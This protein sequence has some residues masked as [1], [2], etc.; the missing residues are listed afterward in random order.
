MEDFLIFGGLIIT[1]IILAG[2][3]WRLY[4]KNKI[5]EREVVLVEK[6]KDEYAQLGRGLAQYNQKLQEKKEEAKN[7]ILEM[8]A[9]QARISNHDVAKSLE[10]SSMSAV[11]YLDELEK[12]GKIKQVGKTGKKVFYTK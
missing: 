5:I 2:V 1:I 7:K 4:E 8:V 10:V 6:E 3:A 9:A 12:E 11:R